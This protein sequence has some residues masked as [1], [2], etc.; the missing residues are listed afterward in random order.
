MLPFKNSKG[1]KS[2]P[3]GDMRIFGFHKLIVVWDH[4]RG[5]PRSPNSPVYRPFS[6]HFSLLAMP[7]CLEVKTIHSFYQLSWISSARI[8]SFLRD[9]IL[10]RAWSTFLGLEQMAV[11]SDWKWNAKLRCAGCWTMQGMGGS[12]TWLS[13]RKNVL[14]WNH[15]CKG[16]SGGN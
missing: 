5:W 3:L 7:L 10:Y 12:G 15:V 9:L 16:L 4:H 11:Q 8:T 14:D 6:D 2:K 1:H 13:Y